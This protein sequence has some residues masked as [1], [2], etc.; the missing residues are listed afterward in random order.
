MANLNDMMATPSQ[1]AR[2]IRVLI[3]QNDVM[4]GLRQLGRPSQ[5]ALRR[6]ID[7]LVLFLLPILISVAAFG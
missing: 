5:A 6:M 3:D 1:K 7:P 2:I 4:P